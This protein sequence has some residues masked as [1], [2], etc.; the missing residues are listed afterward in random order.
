MRLCTVA[1]CVWIPPG[2]AM[3]GDWILLL[4]RCIAPLWRSTR[5]VVADAGQA[6]RKLARQLR[7]DGWSLQNVNCKQ[8]A[9]RIADLTWIV[10][11]SFARLGFNRRL[12]KVYEC[13]V[14]TSE[15]LLDVVAIRLTFNRVAPGPV[16]SCVWIR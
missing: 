16:T 12:S 4:A 3:A 14:Q 8:R 7:R 5:T 9:F 1:S 10:E 13:H 15:A 11:R 2:L 6:S